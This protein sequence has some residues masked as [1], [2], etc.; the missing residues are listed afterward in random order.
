MYNIDLASRSH[1]AETEPEANGS[2]NDE[3]G[4]ESKTEKKEWEDYGRVLCRLIDPFER[5]RIIVDEGLR[6][7]VDDESDDSDEVDSDEQAANG[8]TTRGLQ[9]YEDEVAG[10]YGIANP[11][12]NS[13]EVSGDGPH[14]LYVTVKF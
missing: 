8:G 13:D 11:S 14:V 9:A 2:A 12:S 5:P 6:D 7:E 1:R 10:D 4:V 3:N